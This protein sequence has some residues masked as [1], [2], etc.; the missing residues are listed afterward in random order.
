MVWYMNSISLGVAET[1][2]QNHQGWAIQVN[3][4]TDSN[5]WGTNRSLRESIPWAA[6]GV[7]G[8]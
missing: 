7:E 8:A 5:E 4:G 6:E 3:L 2:T 1:S